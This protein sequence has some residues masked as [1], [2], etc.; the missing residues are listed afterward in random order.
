MDNVEYD[1]SNLPAWGNGDG[2]SY[3]G[4]IYNANGN[5]NNIT[6]Q[7]INNKASSIDYSSYGGAVCNYA[8]NLY[9]NYNAKSVIL[10]VILSIIRL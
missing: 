9:P 3:G 7:F 8:N 5:D 6:G 4:A 2:Y 1:S 10:P